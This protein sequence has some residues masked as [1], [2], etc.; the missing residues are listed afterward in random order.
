MKKMTLILF[1]AFLTLSN[2]GWAAP[3]DRTRVAAEA[4]WLLHV[5]FEAF[6]RTELWR[7][8]NQE[9]S[10][11]IRKKI[12]EFE[13]FLGF[14]PT[15]DIFGVTIFGTD[16]NEKN[17][18][19]A[20]YG[21]FDKEKL[22]TMIGYNPS[23]R[24]SKYNDRIL[25]H[26]LDEKDNKQMVGIF[27]T[28]SMVVIS[29]SIQAVQNMADVLAGQVNSLAS[30]EDAPLATLVDAPKNAFLVMA[31]DG[32]A[33]LQKDNQDTEFLQKSKSI[34]VAVGETNGQ[35]HLHTELTADTAD[36][37]IQI[38]QVLI[39]IKAF[40]ELKNAKEQSEITSLLQAVILEQK[41]NK[42]FLTLQYSTAKLF[43]L[44]KSIKK[45]SQEKT[46]N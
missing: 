45:S 41:E 43:E 37:A 6:E 22:L 4:K 44:A 28:D 16:S 46:T 23:Y 13:S 27:A 29:Q 15:K 35:L 33:E 30:Q 2:S 36:A 17:A 14:D 7:L 42:L 11:D 12:E 20:I 40:F 32:L 31:A 9:I 5:D 19:V 38:E 1:S 8:I 10:E 3:L 34:S 18:V 25:Y 26:W 21:R 24:E 39:G